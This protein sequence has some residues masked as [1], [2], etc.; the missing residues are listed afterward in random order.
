MAYAI[1]MIQPTSRKRDTGYSGVSWTCLFFGPFPA[2]YRGHL[3]GFIGMT[4]VNLATLG[5][6]TFVFIFVYNAWH[7]HSLL[8]R[9]FHPAGHQFG[10]V[11][12]DIVEVKA[13]KS[14]DAE[15]MFEMENLRQRRRIML[16]SPEL[17]ENLIDDSR[18]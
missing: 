9:G 5:L 14:K 13:E 15:D 8:S 6:S 10:T 2:L 4:I 16:A 7:Y 1:K 17:S 3:F 11:R 12:E 18:R